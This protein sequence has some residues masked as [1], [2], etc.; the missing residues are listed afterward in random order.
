MRIAINGK[1]EH[2]GTHDD[3]RCTGPPQW[4]HGI[5]GTT[6]AHSADAVRKG[7]PFFFLSAF[8]RFKSTLIAQETTVFPS[9]VHNCLI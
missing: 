5:P 1:V 3:Q 6:D 4:R 7:R 8:L 9:F 2:D